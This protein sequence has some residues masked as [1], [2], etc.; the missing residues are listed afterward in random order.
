MFYAHARRKFK[1]FYAI[2]L[3]DEGCVRNI[4]WVDVK[5]RDDYREFEDVIFFDTTYITNKYKIPMQL[6]LFIGVNN[7]FPS[8]LL[9]CTLLV[10]ET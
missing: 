9:G 10:D 2:D 1:L 6:A 3:D 8:T 7:L 4:R 5:G